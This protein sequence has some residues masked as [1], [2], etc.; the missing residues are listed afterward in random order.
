VQKYN[1]FQFLLN[2]II[3]QLESDQTRL[4]VLAGSKNFRCL[5]PKPES[6]I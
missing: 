2:Q 1:G 5:E 4:G 6:D 3:L